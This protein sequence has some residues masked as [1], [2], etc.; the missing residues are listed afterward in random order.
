MSR[1]RSQK[2]LQDEVEG[3]EETEH[4]FIGINSK[5]F[6]AIISSTNIERRDLKLGTLLFGVIDHV[7]DK[8][9]TVSFPGSNTTVLSV[10]NTL[11]GSD[12]IPSDFLC[13]LSKKSLRDRFESGQYING[14]VIS[15]NKVKNNITLKP[16]ILN[17]GIN[18]N[19]K[20]LTISGYVIS[21]MIISKEGHG[22][23]VYAGIQGIK[24]VFMKVKESGE[25]N[26]QIGQILP[27][28][29]DK[30]FREK[31]LLVCTPIYDEAQDSVIKGKELLSI[32]EIKPGLKVECLV[33]S[34]STAN[35][36]ERKG[37]PQTPSKKRKVSDKVGVQPNTKILQLKNIDRQFV[38]DQELEA[39]QKYL[40]EDH[41]LQVSFCMGTMLGIIP[42]EHCAH[43][44][45]CFYPQ[46]FGSPLGPRATRSSPKSKFIT[47][48]IIAVLSGSENKI[49]LSALPHNLNLSRSYQTAL[50]EILIG[51]VIS[52][53]SSPHPEGPAPVL[54]RL[55]SIT[56][57]SSQG[58][59]GFLARIA[60]RW[61]SFSTNLSTKD[62]DKADSAVKTQSFR[63]ISRSRLE[64]SIFVS[65]DPNVVKE[66][67]FSSQDVPPGQIVKAKVT[68]IHSWG[69]SVRLSDYF[70]GRIYKEH[71]FNSSS[72]RSGG[73][74]AS[75]T[76]NSSKNMSKEQTDYVKKHYQIGRSYQFKVLR[77]EYSDHSWNPLL[78]LTAKHL[79]INDK[80]PLINSVDESLKVG[81]KATGY[82]SRICLDKTQRQSSSASGSIRSDKKDYIIVRFYGEV[83]GSISYREYLDHF[84]FEGIE[85][86]VSRKPVIGEVIT[87]Q[88]KSIDFS[89]KSLKLTLGTLGEGSRDPGLSLASPINKQFLPQL[90]NHKHS[91]YE[92]LFEKANMNSRG[93]T[94]LGV[95]TQGLL[96]S[97]E[98]R[99]LLYVSKYSISDSKENSEIIY[100]LLREIYHSSESVSDLNSKISSLQFSPKTLSDHVSRKTLEMELPRG[101]SGSRTEMNGESCSI[102]LN[103]NVKVAYLKSSALN[104]V[105]VV[106][107]LVVGTICLGYINHIDHYGL[108]VSIL[109]SES[110][111]GIVP[112]SLISSKIFYDSKEQL[113]KHFS[114]GE[115][116]ILK[117][118]KLDEVAKKIT[119]SLKDLEDGTA[120]VQKPHF[121]RS[122]LREKLDGLGRDDQ[123]INCLIN[124]F[125]GVY[126]EKSKKDSSVNLVGNVLKL[127]IHSKLGEEGVYVA[128]LDLK[129]SQEKIC[130]K[131]VFGAKEGEDSKKE[132]SKGDVIDA[133]VLARGYPPGMKT[134]TTSLEKQ[135]LSFKCMYFV[136]CEDRVVS[137]FSKAL[138][139]TK[140]IG[141]QRLRSKYSEF[142][143]T[144]VGETRS[145]RVERDED[146]FVYQLK[147][148]TV[149]VLMLKYKGDEKFPAVVLS[150]T[151]Q[152]DRENGGSQTLGCMILDHTECNPVLLGVLYFDIRSGLSPKSLSSRSGDLVQVND[153]VECRIVEHMKSYQGLIVQL[154]N[155]SFGRISVMELDDDK[156]DKPLE[157]SKFK[158]GETIQGIV[159][160][161]PEN[162]KRSRKVSLSG[163]SPTKL[164]YVTLEYEVSS[165]ISK[166][167]D[168][169]DK[170]RVEEIETFSQISVGSILS[171]YVY[172][173]GKE[174][175][176]VR[177][178]RDLVGRI[179]LRELTSGTITPEDA[180][181][182][183]FVGKFIQ[184]MVVVNLNREEKKV[185]LSISKLDSDDIKLRLS[186]LESSRGET[187]K[188][189]ARG[190]RQGGKRPG[191]GLDVDVDMSGEDDVAAT[192]TLGNIN[193]K[194]SFEDLFVGRILGG[195]IKNVSEKHGLFIRL[196]DLKDDLTAL[197][198]F[199]EC[200]DTK[201]NVET[202]S[203]IFKVGE[204]V[205]C[206]V[207]RI[208]SE[209]RRVW[210]GIKPSYF[211]KLK[212]GGEEGHLS[213]LGAKECVEEDDTDE[214][215]TGEGEDSGNESMYDGEEEEGKDAEMSLELND[216]GLE[217]RELEHMND[218]GGADA[219][220]G[221][222][223]SE[224]GGSES[225]RGPGD[226]AGGGPKT[227]TK[228]LSRLQ[229]VQRQ[230]EQEHRIRE[231]EEKGMRSHLNP[232]TIDDFER[233]LVTHRDVSS[234]WIKYMSYYLDLGELDKA[235]M[236]AERSL[237]QISVKEEMER[238]NMWIAYINMEIVYGKDDV[239]A[240]KGGED[241]PKNVR[242]VLDRALMNVS[243]QK[244]LYIQ[245]FS[246]LRRYSKEEHGL[247]LLEEGLKKFQTSRK[248]WMT[249][250]TCLYEG[251]NQ[252]K[253]REE[254]IQKSLKSVSKHKVVR[255][256]TDIGRLEFDYG[257]VNRGRT[258]FE[259]LLEENPRRMDLWSQY[260]DILTKLC[261]GPRSK[262]PSR[263]GGGA[264][265]I[266]M[267]RSVFSSCLER[268]FKP[269]SMK[270]IFTRWLSFEKQFGSL[271]SQKHVQDLA[272]SYVN[273]VE[274]NL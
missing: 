239:Y 149:S 44:L 127:K 173:S 48:R 129:K 254:V 136:T 72:S 181:K 78:L 221:L 135:L 177:I 163:K 2:P 143:E 122:I 86:G 10:E 106:K 187:V 118:A 190:D 80:L 241:I 183:F 112:R 168:I 89:S 45:A 218:G 259:N 189:S 228:N 71:I 174:G 233:L 58:K 3:L 103:L 110:L 123:V 99:D 1:K 54:T 96:F 271:Q 125:L 113:M 49:V 76:S 152:R 82:I 7:T 29:V 114:V 95:T 156:N 175:V 179:K 74:G 155:K 206:K 182:R 257:N 34:H 212:E 194:L 246:S 33:H 38:S 169:Q 229:K 219:C 119:L 97:Q 158:V 93:F 205:L 180:S 151:L 61:V 68:D 128:T 222:S 192:P 170:D 255:L 232:S 191:S 223:F 94:L 73:V 108:L 88:I 171:G 250:L 31:S 4:D 83:Y 133:L 87:V 134:S 115:T 105:A 153:K 141:S 98:F 197:C 204:S 224:L 39:V 237:R 196:S 117:V 40:Q 227:E 84:E 230:L 234:L 270:M 184:R 30:Y 130:F 235:R 208:S 264:D 178:G 62:Y 21:G 263:G 60:D 41:S 35:Q 225:K 77:Y 70:S 213:L 43:P 66:K 120:L 32:H 231:E 132:L 207:L 162:K 100:N 59:I 16:S 262:A 193:E 18:S 11:E 248:M 201:S 274:S 267:A 67:Y 24:S 172:N 37:H 8:E 131:L 186:Q 13:D 17:A 238:W 101:S 256:I 65:F 245:A 148:L 251:D 116:L 91:F 20:C 268:N 138:E 210:V 146:G 53:P 14:A 26:Y 145:V 19:S 253:A 50:D 111:T 240:S 23:N 167:R 144:L 273:K 63:V 243:D 215:G 236:V 52:S 261:S 140:K 200:L 126:S 64:N 269:R 107:N 166:I 42:G 164:K 5:N 69:V 124:R 56:M 6:K 247:A 159:I 185:D 47:A 12:A 46:G 249:Y 154:P 57:S 15:N 211:S 9:L 102:C 25:R 258:I 36:K 150:P 142:L 203:S 244:K 27:V 217:Y 157:L 75:S 28:R 92:G 160:D 161:K 139:T 195:V 226:S 272:I 104:G 165:R 198:K 242:E 188:K 220:V 260:F 147:Q 22:F 85:N 81:Q 176:F 137:S 90:G 202:I 209:R 51:S 265:H 199:S 121:T 79:L 216:E 214:T 109:S 55:S 266:E 252:K